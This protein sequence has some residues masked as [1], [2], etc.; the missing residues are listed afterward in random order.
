MLAGRR[1]G[2]ARAGSHPPAAEARIVA[3]ILV[4]AARRVVTA[5]TLG[6]GLD[7]LGDDTAIWIR[8]P[9]GASLTRAGGG[10]WEQKPRHRREPRRIDHRLTLLH[11]ILATRSVRLRRSASPANAQATN[12][13]A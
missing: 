12:Q 4:G 1:L 6:V 3:A 7:A 8:H 9:A 2:S 5:V 13:L 11:R 10:E